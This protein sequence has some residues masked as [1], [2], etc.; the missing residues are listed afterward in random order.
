MVVTS[1]KVHGCSGNWCAVPR[2]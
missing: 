2:S 1:D